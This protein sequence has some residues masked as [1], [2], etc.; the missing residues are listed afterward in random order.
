LASHRERPS[1][2]IEPRI[3][4]RLAAFVVLTHVAA[5]ATVLALPGAWSLLDLAVA[6]SLAYRLYVQVLRR[7]PWSIRSVLWQ[8]DGTWRITL[9]S[10]R[11][12]EATLSP[13]TFVS[14]PLIVLNLR[15]G[16]LRRRALPLFS[17]ALKTEQLRRLRQRLRIDGTS[18][19]ENAAPA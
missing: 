17:D 6:A 7:T 9:V 13:S 19:D 3:S 8:S 10:G 18:R 12:L 15:L 11:E 2:L 4:G 1:L 14:V 5:G 16:R